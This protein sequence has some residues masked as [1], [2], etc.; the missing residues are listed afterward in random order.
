MSLKVSIVAANKRFKFV[1]FN[2][3][4]QSKIKSVFFSSKSIKHSRI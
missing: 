3:W 1:R 2:N 4:G